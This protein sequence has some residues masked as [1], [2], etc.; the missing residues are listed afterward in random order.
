MSREQGRPAWEANPVE[1]DEEVINAVEEGC[2]PLLRTY[3]REEETD[4]PGRWL[5]G[6]LGPDASFPILQ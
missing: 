6:G 5:E 4:N 3:P 2:G 1:K